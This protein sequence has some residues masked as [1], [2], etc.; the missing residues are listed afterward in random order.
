MLV[1]DPEI[2]YTPQKLL[3]EPFLQQSGVVQMQN[4]EGFLSTNESSGFNGKQNS[5]SNQSSAVQAA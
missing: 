5:G 3:A 2:R 4:S 1:V